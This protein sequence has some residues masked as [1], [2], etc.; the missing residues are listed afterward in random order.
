MSHSF[1]LGIDFRN[2]L[3]LATWFYASLSQ[4]RTPLG[5]IE[6]C[7]VDIE[8]GQGL[9]VKKSTESKTDG[10]DLKKERRNKRTETCFKIT[11][12]WW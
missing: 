10:I 2:V 6:Y 11:I 5:E 1:P 3:I 9:E 8:V 7:S 12:V 4:Q